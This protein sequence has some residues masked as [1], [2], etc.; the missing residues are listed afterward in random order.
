MRRSIRAAAGR[1]RGAK[2]GNAGNAD[3]S[4]QM[5]RTGIGTDEE[6]GELEDCREL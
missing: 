1:R 4:G 6:A 2:Q 5:E 3:G